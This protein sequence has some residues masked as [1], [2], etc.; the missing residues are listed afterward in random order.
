MESSKNIEGKIA[1]Y[2][3]EKTV[4]ER[5]DTAEEIDIDIETDVLKIVQGQAEKVSLSGK[6]IVIQKNIRVQ[7]IQLQT[8]NITINPFRAILGQIELN[9]PVKTVARIVLTKTDI[10]LACT[11]DLIRSLV[12]KITLNVDGEIIC[13]APQ[14]IT[15]FL[16]GDGKIGLNATGLLKSEKN[17]RL[18]G[19]TVTCRP[20]NNSHPILLESVTCTE[21]EGIS[22][23]LILAFMQKIKELANLPFLKWEDIAFRIIDMEVESEK[24]I[25]M[26]EANVQQISESQIEFINQ[27]Q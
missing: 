16:P 15:I 12:E 13:F 5:I 2:Q 11:S 26:V 20:R 8:D 17:T 23:E 25:L 18:L 4:S 6:G 24:I 22:V 3:A 21:G 7:E 9:Q 19:V 27:L 10:N 1:S 14:N